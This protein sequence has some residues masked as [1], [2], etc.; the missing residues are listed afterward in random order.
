MDSYPSQYQFDLHGRPF[1]VKSKTTYKGQQFL[2]AL[3]EYEKYTVEE[4]M[5]YIQSAFV[6]YILPPLLNGKQE[7]FGKFETWDLSQAGKELLNGPEQ[8]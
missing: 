7:F 1:L 3:I 4:L 6:E 8:L 2:T 5:P